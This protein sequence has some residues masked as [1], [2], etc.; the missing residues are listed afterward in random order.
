MNACPHCNATTVKV[1]CLGFPGRLCERC[2]TASGFAAWAAE[3]FLIESHNLDDTPT[4]FAFLVYEGGYW[5]AL[6]YWLKG[7]V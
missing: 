4:V 1:I 5:R 7:I 3:T 6:R 2:G